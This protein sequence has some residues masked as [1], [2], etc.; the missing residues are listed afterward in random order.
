MTKLATC[1]LLC[2]AAVDLATDWIAPP[3]ATETA[4]GPR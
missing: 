3:P 4:G 2:L 1:I